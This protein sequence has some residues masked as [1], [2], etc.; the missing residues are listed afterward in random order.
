METCPKCGH[1]PHC[2][3]SDAPPLRPAPTYPWLRPRPWYGYQPGTVAPL[4]VGPLYQ[5][6]D[7]PLYAPTVTC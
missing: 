2:G 6:G 1:C 4:T 7:F 3:R 5:T